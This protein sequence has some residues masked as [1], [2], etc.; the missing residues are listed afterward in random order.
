MVALA[1]SGCLGSK[2]SV[3]YW[4]DFNPSTHY[5]EVPQTQSG[6]FRLTTEVFLSGDE[7]FK[8]RATHILSFLPAGYIQQNTFPSGL[9]GGDPQPQNIPPEDEFAHSLFWLVAEVSNL[10]EETTGL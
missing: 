2:I 7:N 6:H 4:G 3:A 8:T 5:C 1:H 10:K 9:L